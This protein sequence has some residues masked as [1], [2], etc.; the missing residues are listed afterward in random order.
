MYQINH[1]TK[2]PFLK[3]RSEASQGEGLQEIGIKKDFESWIRSKS[4]SLV[5]EDNFLIFIL[6]F[7]MSRNF[8]T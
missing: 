3:V 1:M 6:S 2:F 7:M 4:S 5:I 8:N